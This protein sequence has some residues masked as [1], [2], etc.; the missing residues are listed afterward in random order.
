M[1]FGQSGK[2][3]LAMDFERQSG[4]SDAVDSTATLIGIDVG[5]F[6]TAVTSS[7]GRRAVI[8]SIVGWPKDETV[9]QQ[10]GREY[11]VGNEV[12]RNR[13]PMEIVFPFRRGA[14]ALWDTDSNG[15]DSNVTRRCYE[16]ADILLAHAI[17]LVGPNPDQPVY[18]AITVPAAASANHKH[19]LL[20]SARS[21]CDAVMLCSAP[22]CVGY[23]AGRIQQS[24]VIDIGASSTNLSVL[25]N[26]HP[27]ADQQITLPIGSDS[28][29]QEL[30]RGI[31][32]SMPGTELSLNTARRIKEK[33]GCLPRPEQ[34]AMV[35]TVAGGPE[36]DVSE[37][38]R[39]ACRQL[40][41][42]IIE[43]VS[44]LIA[45][46]PA[47]R[48]AGLL[49]N[50]LLAGGGGQLKDLATLLKSGLALIGPAEVSVVAD[51]V[52]AASAGALRLATSL[53][54]ADWSRLESSTAGFVKPA[55][56][57][58]PSPIARAA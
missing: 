31:S 33:F 5:S 35:A 18:A 34:T 4:W 23:G 20:K 50:V 54:V 36:M 22:F 51:G 58:E 40:L 53:S 1:G 21:A 52:F 49:Q 6:K 13:V 42:D 25:L 57:K 10:L 8:P 39:Q 30:L 29:D 37:P 24:L 44:E 12:A 56:R 2:P 16:A 41:P 15:A 9:R 48:R 27:S 45:T 32:A 17:S 28:I 38:L 14:L 46:V 26:A 7:N 43:A 19:A 55:A 11:L 3:R 47:D